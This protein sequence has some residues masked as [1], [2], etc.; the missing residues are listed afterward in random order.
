MISPLLHQS[1]LEQL[2]SFLGF[3]YRDYR[4]GLNF[5]GDLLPLLFDR[6]SEEIEKAMPDAVRGILPDWD[7]EDC[8]VWQQSLREQFERM[9][10]KA[11]GKDGYHLDVDPQVLCLSSWGDE[12][13]VFQVL[14]RWEFSS[15]DQEL[16]MRVLKNVARHLHGLRREALRRCER[17]DCGHYFLDA[18]LRAA[19]H[20]SQACRYFAYGP[21]RKRPARGKRRKRG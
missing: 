15:K 7:L 16:A 17:R 11:R 4:S 18:E 5:R 1:H 10:E 12:G 2:R 6:P 3:L 9:I 20:C 19:R 14:P 21:R 8:C 13:E